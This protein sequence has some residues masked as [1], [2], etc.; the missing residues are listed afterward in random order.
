VFLFKLF[1]FAIGGVLKLVILS[2]LFVW[3]FGAAKE[4]APELAATVAEVKIGDIV[5]VIE[6]QADY[7]E[8]RLSKSETYQAAKKEFTDRQLPDA[9]SI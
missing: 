6:Q 3:S 5:K 8:Y 1:G 9:Q 7:L 4:Y 2:F